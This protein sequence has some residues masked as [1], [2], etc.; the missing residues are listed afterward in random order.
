MGSSYSIDK[1]IEKFIYN[2]PA[3]THEEFEKLNTS[4]SILVKLESGSY[5]IAA[6]FNKPS[7]YVHYET[8]STL[9]DFLIKAPHNYFV[10]A[11]G[12]G[13]DIYATQTYCQQ[14]ADMLDVIVFSFDYPGY[15]LSSPKIASESNCY[16]S[17]K[18]VMTFLLK[19][20]KIS[21][22]R[23]YLVGRSL[24]T[25][26]VVDYAYK[27][28]WINPILL[29]SPYKT[30]NRVVCD[31]SIMRPVDKFSNISKIGSLECPIK[32]IHGTNDKVIDISH[33]KYLYENTKNKIKPEWIEDRG[34]ND[35]LYAI[36]K[37]MFMNVMN[38]VPCD[39]IHKVQ[40]L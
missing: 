21:K 29:I 35:I 22:S 19:N 34:H 6:V 1:Q 11:H 16:A 28:S 4:T 32:I 40:V 20:L 39:N 36:T 8:Y 33:G 14:M 12:N 10:Y 9:D 27:Q 31:T 30:I 17:M 7:K 38:H 25:G 2:P 26:V 37:E 18:V 15:G 13:A 3:T 5:S 24:G 23:I